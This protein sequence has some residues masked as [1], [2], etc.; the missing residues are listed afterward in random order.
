MIICRVKRCFFNK[1]KKCVLP[2]IEINEQ[3]KCIAY[4]MRKDGGESADQKKEQT[5]ALN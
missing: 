3:R 2:R 4:V 1:D 5:E